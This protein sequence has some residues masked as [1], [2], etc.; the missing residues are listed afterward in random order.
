[1]SRTLIAAS[2]LALVSVAA[3]AVAVAQDGAADRIVGAACANNGALLKWL[4][5]L[6]GTT[7]GASL[8]ANFRN[9]L[10][11]GVAS[12]LDVLALNFVR[13]VESSA[14]AAKK[15]TP[16]L[17]ALLL[18]AAAL[19]ACAQDNPLAQAPVITINPQTGSATAAAPTVAPTNTGPL[20]KVA[21]ALGNLY[22]VDDVAALNMACGTPPQDPIGCSFYTDLAGLANSL[23]GQGA[24][25]SAPGLLA[26]VEQARRA[27]TQLDA[28]AQN[29]LLAQT[30]ADGLLFVQDTK[31]KGLAV[32]SQVLSLL[33]SINAMLLGAVL[34]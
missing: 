16:A 3:I 2:A 10:P 32:P 7:A 21:V 30:L 22:S 34:P 31:A 19:S 23:K 33:P 6:F 29:K 9:R 17:L 24:S 4:V 26:K 5:G 13:A 15:S 28:V 12:V 27:L 1:M 11:A 18:A 20:E 14:S 8:L 25:P